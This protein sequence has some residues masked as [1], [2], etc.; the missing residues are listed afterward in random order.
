[1]DPCRPSR[2]PARVQTSVLIQESTMAMD[3]PIGTTCRSCA[4]V[5]YRQSYSGRRRREG[6][7]VAAAILLNRRV[8]LN[9]LLR[10]RADPVG[11]LTVVRA[12]LHPPLANGAAAWS[13][14]RL[15]APETERVEAGAFDGGDDDVEGAGGDG[16][17]DGVLAVGGGAPAE[18]RVVVDVRAVE[19]GSVAGEES[20]SVTRM[21]T[22]GDAKL[23]SEGGRVYEK[24]E[25][26]L[27]DDGV[28]L[29]AHALDPA[30]LSLVVD[31]RTDVL[32]VAVLT[33]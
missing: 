1:M 18:V 9:A 7:H 19:E 12:L 20:S 11:R 24:L 23:P 30:T 5:N 3:V 14:V 16:A 31:L 17:L 29:A 13:V 27:V 2:T 15:A 4:A 26:L 32:R 28:A 22:R 6:T 25:G 21:G 33:D 8:T 10:V